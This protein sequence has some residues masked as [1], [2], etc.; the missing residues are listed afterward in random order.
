MKYMRKTAASSLVLTLAFFAGSFCL[1][2]MAAQAM[3]TAM[4]MPASP[5][6]GDMEAVVSG[7]DSAITPWNLCVVDCA[8][9]TPQAIASKK[10]S[11]DFLGGLLADAVG[12]RESR[13]FVFS[14][15][16]TDFSGTHPPSPDI[17]SSV[18]KKE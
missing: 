7:G 2:P 1:H 14:S 10:F 13:V 8:S 4:A 15:G 16:P 12:S 18:F 11:V 5:E 17:L 9:E 3:D 6:G